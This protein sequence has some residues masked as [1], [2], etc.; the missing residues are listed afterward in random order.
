M[1]KKNQ[2]LRI[3][4]KKAARRSGKLTE[5][6]GK[7]LASETKKKFTMSQK[8]VATIRKSRYW[9]GSETLQI[10]ISR[11]FFVALKRIIFD[12]KPGHCEFKNDEGR[13]GNDIPEIN[14]SKRCQTCLKGTFSIAKR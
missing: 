11:N 7:V 13:L 6:E 5:N 10:L 4:L 8:R 12:G 14:S 9:F 3:K 1:N 2:K